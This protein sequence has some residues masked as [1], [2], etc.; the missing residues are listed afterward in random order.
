MPKE[1]KKWPSYRIAIAAIFFVIG[2]QYATWSTRLPDYMAKFSLDSLGVAGILLSVSIGSLISMPLTGYLLTR[3]ES[4][5]VLKVGLIL[6]LLVYP[7]FAIGF[8]YPLMILTG[9][10]LG[11]TTGSIDIS[12]NTQGLEIEQNL[13]SPIISSFHAIFSAGML[14]GALL[15]SLMVKIGLSLQAHILISEALFI[16]I[17]I[18][19]F[20]R[21]YPSVLPENDGQGSK[22]FI[23]T[24]FL[25]LLGIISFTSMMSEGAMA[26]WSV[27]YVIEVIGSEEY[28]G[29]IAQASFSGAMMIGRFGGDSIRK[30]WSVPIL[31]KISALL[32]FIGLS[33][34]LIIP[35]NWSM[36]L[37]CILVG[38]GLSNLV[39]VVF[40]TAG[41]IKNVPSGIGISTASTLGY[42]GFLVGPPIIG[43]LSDLAEGQP[44]W[45]F[46]GLRFGLSFIAIMML[47]LLLLG[48]TSFKKLYRNQ[49]L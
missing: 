14:L 11:I 12:M 34:F 22:K 20:N 27:L 26:D 35:A 39:P 40:S 49:H 29:P 30:K 32:S 5:K 48:I 17:A 10:L 37:G 9:V 25:I 21:L 33:I 44:F 45:P 36:M 16:G 8:T 3:Y 43:F 13:N 23:F 47:L 15:S 42:S 18:Y 41:S 38:L 4:Q 7:I 19:C 24:P 6:F 46:H 31:I 1:V 28:L 2:V